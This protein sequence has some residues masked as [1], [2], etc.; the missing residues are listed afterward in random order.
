MNSPRN[1]VRRNW[2]MTTALYS[3]IAASSALGFAAPGEAAN[4]AA[5]VKTDTPI[6]HLIV[7]IGENRGLDHTFGVYK[8]AGK[9]EKISNLLSKGIV[10]ADGSPGSNFTSVPQFSVAAQPNWYFGAPLP[11]NAT[12]CARCHHGR[13][14]V[15]NTS[16][17][18]TRPACGSPSR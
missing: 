14:A 13:C 15:N 18:P 11:A 2:R 1:V 3:S 16:R 10:K 4:A 9:G 17:R 6:K 12:G 7:L 8:P 5:S